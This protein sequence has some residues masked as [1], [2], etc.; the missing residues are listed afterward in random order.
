MNEWLG[1][2][3]RKGTSVTADG[4]VADGKIFQEKRGAAVKLG[5][6]DTGPL[7]FGQ[8]KEIHPVRWGGHDEKRTGPGGLTCY[9]G[10]SQ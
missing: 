5:H 10:G 3:A 9:L 6:T 7:G 4:E 8:L 1:T 2:P